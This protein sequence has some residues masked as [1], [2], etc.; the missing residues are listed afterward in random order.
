MRVAAIQF[1]SGLDKSANVAGLAALARDAAAR[2]AQLI[3]TPEM[4]TR[5][6]RDRARALNEAH[7]SLDEPAFQELAALSAALNIFLLLGSAPFRVGAA[8]LANRSILF[9]PTGAVLATYD[10]IHMFDVDLG[11]G[12]TYRESALYRPGETARLVDLGPAKLGLSICYDIRFARLYLDLARA[13]AEIIAAPS[14]F[15]M[16]TGLA[17]WEILLRAR[18]IESGAFVIAAAQG[19]QHE[20]GRRT[21][22]RSMIIGPWGEVIAALDHDQPDILLADLDLGAVAKARRAIPAWKTDQP[23]RSAIAEPTRDLG[24]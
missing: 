19:G 23:F 21:F 22:G 7:S 5:L 10:K 18:A 12:E 2:G 1:R 6:D 13:G 15:T 4:S 9:G 11:E 3:V 17:H 16:P 24:A 20:D 8:A 14:A